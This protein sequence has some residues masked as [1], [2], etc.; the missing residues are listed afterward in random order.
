MKNFID[1]DFLLENE[2]AKTLYNYAK[3]FP[4]IDY[5]CHISP[6]EIAEDR[7]FKNITELWL[8]GDH[9]KWRLM[10]QN[11]VDEK[12]I[13]GSAPDRDKFQKWA[14]TLEKAAGNPIYVWSHLELRRYFG[15]DGILNGMAAGEVWELC[16][17]KLKGLSARKFIEMSNVEL[18]CT[19]DDPADDLR[20]HKVIAADA[21]FK[22]RVLPS[23]RPD[24]PLNIELDGFA[25]YIS[26]LSR[27]AETEINSFADLK[28][29]LIK[30]IEY[31]D[32]LG[33][34]TADHGLTKAIYS[35]C[36]E[37]E[38]ERVF[39][40]ALRGEK[41]NLSDAEKHKTALL[42]FLGGE[43]K[44]RGWVM[45][46]HY[47]CDRN[48]NTKMFKELGPDTGLDCI[49]PASPSAYLARLLDGFGDS[50]PK[51]IVYSLDPS[52]NTAIDSISGCFSGVRHGAAWWFNDNK[53]GILNQ[54]TSA[55]NQG[56]L[57]SFTGMLTDSRSFLSYTRHEYFRRIFCNFLAGLAEGGEYPCDE[58]ALRKIVRGVCHG[59]AAEFFGF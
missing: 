7:H 30:R 24:K 37:A 46:L 58:R 36:E 55:A 10:R 13:T 59:N 11:S 18:I 39:A 40:A 20:W 57:G 35:P 45:Q 43:Y 19:T 23:F 28:T 27:A 33:C 53:A 8:G 17:E 52:E 42:I 29:A 41:I 56:L 22:V 26:A 54:L 5:H 14:E 34:R 6:K 1:N 21:G 50:L 3:D 9:Y 49:N 31:F 38:A 4:I 48:V 2:T 15:Y 16:G 12:Y 32:A 44:K 51:T 25:G 47:G